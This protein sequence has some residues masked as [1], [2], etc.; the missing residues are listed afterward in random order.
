[1]AKKNRK[2]RGGYAV[3]WMVLG[4]ALVVTA[5]GAI[6]SAVTAPEGET[7]AEWVTA[8]T[9]IRTP[10]EPTPPGKTPTWGEWAGGLYDTVKGTASGLYDSVTTW[11]SGTPNP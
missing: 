5:L 7:W 4:V 6:L 8:W 9:T 1:M 2:K 3:V 11:W 10:D